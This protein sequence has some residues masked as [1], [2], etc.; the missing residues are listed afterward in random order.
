MSVLAKAVLNAMVSSMSTGMN[1]IIR[2]YAA[3]E[4]TVFTGT[5]ILFVP[6][7]YTQTNSSE[8]K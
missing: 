8:A 2:I 6:T 7:H 1:V 3:S 4:K 5:E